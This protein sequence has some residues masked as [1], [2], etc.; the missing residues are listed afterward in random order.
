MGGIMGSMDE[1]VRG[2]DQESTSQHQEVRSQD[3][4]ALESDARI[5]R[6]DRVAILFG[7][8]TA[9]TREF[10]RALAE[11][12]RHRDWEDEGFGSCSSP[13]RWPEAKS[14]LARSAR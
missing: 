6:M 4:A 8:I 13:R 12:D 9:A 10:L 2:R 3:Q 7:E 5:E 11:S 1:E 14:R